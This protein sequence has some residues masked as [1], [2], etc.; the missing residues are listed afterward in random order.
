MTELKSAISTA[1]NESTPDTISKSQATAAAA[2]TVEAMKGDPVL[3]NAT[4]QEPL[5]QSRIV[6]G[7]STGAIA[8]IVYLIFEVAKNGLNYAAYDQAALVAALVALWGAAYALYGRLTP[9]LK[10]MFHGWFGIGK[11]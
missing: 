2:K 11:K 4:N 8:S 3:A 5:V 7:G 1:I 6:V 9:G 10:P